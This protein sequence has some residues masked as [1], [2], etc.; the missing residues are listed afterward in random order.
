ML[1]GSDSDILNKAMIM[2]IVRLAQ[3]NDFGV[4]PT[5]TIDLIHA[6]EAPADNKITYANFVADY[7]PLKPE[8]NRKRCVAG[9]D[10]T[11]VTPD[12]QLQ[13]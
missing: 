3:C 6:K 2:E 10:S 8:P 7:H 12:L 5:D 13:P 1:R 11:K 4:S 9:G